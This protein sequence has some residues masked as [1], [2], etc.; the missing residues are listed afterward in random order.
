MV[1]KVRKAALKEE[2]AKRTGDRKLRR[3]TTTYILA[4]REWVVE[5]T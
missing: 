4:L 3:G 5:K 1:E 2:F